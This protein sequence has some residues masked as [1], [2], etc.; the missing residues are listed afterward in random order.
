MTATKV[1]ATTTTTMKATTTTN[2]ESDEQ[3][4]TS[5]DNDDGHDNDLRHAHEDDVKGEDG[6]GDEDECQD[7]SMCKYRKDYELI[8][9][10]R[11]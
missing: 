9:R 11:W 3:Q 1:T 2:D 10:R 7:N 8:G 5:D 6:D 4:T